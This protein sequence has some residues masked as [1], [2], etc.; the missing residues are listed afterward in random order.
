[1][2]GYGREDKVKEG[3]LSTV[4]GQLKVIT[5]LYTMSSPWAR[6]IGEY[7]IFFEWWLSVKAFADTWYPC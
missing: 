5:R 4:P 7:Q 1:M 2:K 6:V 3:S